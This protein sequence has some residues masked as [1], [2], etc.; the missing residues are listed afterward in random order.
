MSYSCFQAKFVDIKGIFFY[1]HSPYFCKNQALYIPY[2]KVFVKYQAQ[3]GGYNPKPLAYALVAPPS[4]TRSTFLQLPISESVRTCNACIFSYPKIAKRTET[5]F[6]HIILCKTTVSW[7]FVNLHC[8]I[9][10]HA[11]DMEKETTKTATAKKTT[12]LASENM[13]TVN[14]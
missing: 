4:R 10:N 9:S 12:N 8:R 6:M 2:N 11:M 7:C 13:W 1:T 14:A 3:G 5:Q